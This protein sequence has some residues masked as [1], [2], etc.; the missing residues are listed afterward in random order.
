MI[1]VL[2]NEWDRCDWGVAYQERR[3]LN[4]ERCVCVHVVRAVCVVVLGND[5][6]CGVAARAP[7]TIATPSPTSRLPGATARATASQRRGTA[8]RSLISIVLI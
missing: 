4:R 1:H 8:S 3:E 5:E 7:A 2:I 6:W